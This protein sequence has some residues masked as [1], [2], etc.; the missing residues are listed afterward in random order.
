MQWIK[1]EGSHGVPL[2]IIILAILVGLLLLGLL[3][4]ILY[5][6]SYI[7]PDLAT[8][9]PGSA[10]DPAQSQTSAS[11]SVLQPHAPTS[12]WPRTSHPDTAFRIFLHSTAPGLERVLLTQAAKF[13]HTFK[14]SVT[15]RWPA[16]GICA[17]TSSRTP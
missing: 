7:P 8:L 5:K 11:R 9:S 1:A 17:V 4:Y 3:I 10:P 2:W 6:V 16:Y 14:L 13:A 12:P 15:H